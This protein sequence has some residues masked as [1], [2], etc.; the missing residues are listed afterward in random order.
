ML[1][2]GDF[3]Q[4]PPVMDTWVGKK[5]EK[6]ARNS[7]C[8]RDLCDH[9]CLTLTKNHRSCQRL[10]DFCGSL[11][12]QSLPE[13]VAAARREFSSGEVGRYN[14]VVS[15]QRRMALIKQINALHPEDAILLEAPTVDGRQMNKPQDLWVYPQ[16]EMIASCAKKTN[17]VYNGCLY[18]VL[19]VGEKITLQSN[20]GLLFL[21][22]FNT[23]L[24]IHH[25]ILILPS[26]INFLAYIHF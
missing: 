6:S 11:L 14:L 18:T 21:V 13:A 1:L 23:L 17:G 20:S 9:N 22:V 26:L 16:F 4:L 5:V 3:D 15:H 25:L 8:V 12:R 19:E 10:F 7:D 2:L 24:F